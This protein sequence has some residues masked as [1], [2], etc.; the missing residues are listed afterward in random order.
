MKRLIIFDMDGVI[1]DVS[2]SY[3][4]SVRETA[5]LFFNKAISSEELPE[6]L[7]SLGDLAE[8]KQSGG[9]NND[10][11]LSFLIISSIFSFVKAPEKD[12][13]RMI[14]QK[15]R[16][17]KGGQDFDQ[18][19]ASW[20]LHEEIMSMCDVKGLADFLKSE[21][22]PLTTLVKNK[23]GKKNSLIDI[24]YEGDVGTG[25]IIKQIFQEVYLG[26][27]LFKSIYGIPSRIHK[28]DGYIR[29][30][31]PI[32]TRD[33]LKTLLDENILAIATGRPKIEADY[34]LRRF[35]LSEYFSRVVTL[36]D[37]LGEEERILRERG[38]IASLVK[39][40]PYMLD[41]ISGSIKCDVCKYYYIGDMPD[42]MRAAS[43]SRFPF[44]SVG[45]LPPSRDT[46]GLRNNLLKSGADYII[47]SFKELSDIIMKNER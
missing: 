11:D 3:R 9:L 15:Y 32:I 23:A 28:A 34:A 26:Q 6:P 4:D 10:W 2:G 30:E 16:S 18:E 7:F 27:D 44:K 41:T 29:R 42:D 20:R 33:F 14:V 21:N 5:R 39:P 13:I 12:Y 24:F 43:R 22:N 19:Q 40:S 45:F 17:S 37:C 1:I 25:N 47:D 35:E 38:E 31:E 36:D 46:A 8:V